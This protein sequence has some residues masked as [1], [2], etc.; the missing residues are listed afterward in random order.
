MVIMLLDQFF[1]LLFAV[2]P[3]G[4]LVY[5]SLFGIPSGSYKWYFGPNNQPVFVRQ[6]IKIGCLRIV[7]QAHG[8]GTHLQDDVHVLVVMHRVERISDFSPV[9]VA[10]NSF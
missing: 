7:G 8:V 9:L 10:A 6:I 4:G 2:F 3:E 1:Q 5:I